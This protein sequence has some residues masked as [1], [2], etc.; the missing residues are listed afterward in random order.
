MDLTRNDISP[1]T[2]N[3]EDK[4]QVLKS[5]KRKLLRSLPYQLEA[6]YTDVIYNGVKIVNLF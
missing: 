5:K 2:E 1:K 3:S 4:D 6:H